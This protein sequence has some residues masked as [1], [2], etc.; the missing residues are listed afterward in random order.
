MATCGEK[1]CAGETPGHKRWLKRRIHR[2]MR[3][4][5]KIWAAVRTRRHSGNRVREVATPSPLAKLCPGS[6][7]EHRALNPET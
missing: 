1:I 4:M 5:F 2:W 7:G 6:S 3:R